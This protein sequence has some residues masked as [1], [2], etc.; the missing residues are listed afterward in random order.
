MRKTSQ[1]LRKIAYEQVRQRVRAEGES[2]VVLTDGQTRETR[3]Q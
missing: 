3:D 2:P 1:R